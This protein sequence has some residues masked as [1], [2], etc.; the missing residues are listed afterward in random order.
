MLFMDYSSELNTIVNSKIIT[1][2]G[3]LINPSVCNWVLDFLTGR[4]QV[5]RVGNNTFATLTLNTPS[6]VCA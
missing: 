6:G 1:K 3:T 4:P 2:L 5:V